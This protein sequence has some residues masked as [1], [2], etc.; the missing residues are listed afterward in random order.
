MNIFLS[1]LC[2]VAVFFVGL[3]VGHSFG[4]RAAVRMVGRSVGEAS[5]RAT[6]AIMDLAHEE[7]LDRE[8]EKWFTRE[9]RV[10]REKGE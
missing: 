2:M 9:A 1:A 10:A 7:G 8:M 5:A 4:R 3:A 6:A